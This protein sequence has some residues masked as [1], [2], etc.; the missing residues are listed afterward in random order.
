MVILEVRPTDWA[1]KSLLTFW[2]SIDT[3]RIV[4]VFIPCPETYF[5]SR[6]LKTRGVDGWTFV[7]SGETPRAY[8]H[9]QRYK[10]STILIQDGP[11]EGEDPNERRIPN[12]KQTIRRDRRIR[13]QKEPTLQISKA[14]VKRLRFL[15]KIFIQ[16]TLHMSSINITWSSRKTSYIRVYYYLSY[17]CLRNN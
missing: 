5:P 2:E 6:N 16:T 17:R 15:R 13:K 4:N 14:D 1:L 7:K 9:L 10:V 8:L 11:T 3:D 12:L